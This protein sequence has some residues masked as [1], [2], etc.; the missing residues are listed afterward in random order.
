MKFRSKYF[1]ASLLV[2]VLFIAII[3][4]ACSENVENSASA[5]TTAASAKETEGQGNSRSNAADSLPGDLNF[6]GQTVRVLARGGDADTKIEFFAEEQNADIV[7]EAV[8]KRNL[9]VEER[10]N[11][12]MELKL[13]DSTRHASDVDAIRNSVTAGSDDY[14]L[15]ANHMHYIMCSYYKPYC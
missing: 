7:N 6:D 15:V 5:L 8:Y 4:P 9:A 1:I 12:K 13:T 14:D 11:V 10:L 3:L 2:S